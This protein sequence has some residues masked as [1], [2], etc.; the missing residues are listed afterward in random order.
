MTVPN[1]DGASGGVAAAS[2]A[3]ESEKYQETMR[4]VL[5]WDS[6][7]LFNYLSMELA[8]PKVARMFA[9]DS[10][11][12]KTLSLMERVDFTAARPDGF[13]LKEGDPELET[14]W[15]FISDLRTAKAMT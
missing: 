1:S 5:F 4:T 13:G 8:V 10:I 12:G 3:S 6:P 7:K 14:I 15:S 2:E 11:D 9:E